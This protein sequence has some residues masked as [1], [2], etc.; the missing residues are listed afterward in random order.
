MMIATIDNIVCVGGYDLVMSLNGKYV[1]LLSRED[2]IPDGRGGRKRVPED[3]TVYKILDW[4][5]PLVCAA[6]IDRVFTETA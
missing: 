4:P 2:A 6:V 1:S 5:E 3:L